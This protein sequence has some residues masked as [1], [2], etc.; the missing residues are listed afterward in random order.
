MS[1]SRPF[2]VRN[3]TSKTLNLSCIERDTTVEHTLVERKP[4]FKETLDFFSQD[5]KISGMNQSQTACVQLWLEAQTLPSICLSE[6]SAQSRLALTGISTAV[7][8][9]ASL[10]K[11]HWA[12][13]EKN[14]VYVS[15][16]RYGN[17]H[18][19]QIWWRWREPQKTRRNR[20][21]WRETLKKGKHSSSSQICPFSTQLSI[22]LALGTSDSK[23][24]NCFVSMA[25]FWAEL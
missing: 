12:A 17:H 16:N 10:N 11:P 6:L 22:D 23:T 19:I 1:T 25:I 15:Q 5:G 21:G 4:G 24:A 20:G 18:V 13:L 2:W 8:Q 3:K 7:T 9:P 14:S